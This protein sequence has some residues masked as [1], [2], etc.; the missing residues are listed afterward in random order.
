LKFRNIP[1][2]YRR[3]LLSGVARMPREPVTIILEDPV[4]AHGETLNQL[5]IRPPNG[6]DMVACGVPFDISGAIGKDTIQQMIVRL[7]G[8]PNSSVNA[9]AGSDW[10]Q[11]ANAIMLFLQPLAQSPAAP[12]ATPSLTATSTSPGSG[13]ATQPPSLRSVSTS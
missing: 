10:M 8:I 12:A 3:R 2:A 7:A 1:L 4:E 11:A 9:L 6:A 13:D 5:K